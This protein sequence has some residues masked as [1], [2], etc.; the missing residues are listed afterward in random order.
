[1]GISGETRQHTHIL[2]KPTTHTYS[3]KALEQLKSEAQIQ[4]SG[5]VD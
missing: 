1:M 3:D 2:T 5:A 4:S